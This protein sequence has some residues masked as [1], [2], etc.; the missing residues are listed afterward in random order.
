MWEKKD[1]P[2]DAYNTKHIMTLL[3]ISVAVMIIINIIYD[4][5]VV[6]HSIIVLII[7]IM[8]RTQL[9]SKLSEIRRK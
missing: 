6:R 8:K 7:V 4:F 5:I 2:E 1:T 3:I 9:L